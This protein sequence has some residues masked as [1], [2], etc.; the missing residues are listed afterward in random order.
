MGKSVSMPGLLSS[1]GQ[2]AAAGEGE[3]GQQAHLWEQCPDPR[4]TQTVSE[5][6]Q[7]KSSE[8]CGIESL[9]SLNTVLYF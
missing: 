4:R 2:A 3:A 8:E 7:Q 6:S 5:L 9:L 1:G